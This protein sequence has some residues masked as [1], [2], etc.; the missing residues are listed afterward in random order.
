MPLVCSASI[1]VLCMCYIWI[2]PLLPD[3]DFAEHAL[4]GIRGKSWVLLICEVLVSQCLPKSCISCEKCFQSE[5]E[6]FKQKTG[7]GN[8]F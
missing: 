4:P 1:I 3:V 6:L 7:E 8:V 5:P 2:F